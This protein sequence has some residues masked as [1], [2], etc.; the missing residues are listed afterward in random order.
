MTNRCF[1]Q[2]LS[3][4]KNGILLLQVVMLTVPVTARAGQ[5]GSFELGIS[6]TC[7]GLVV[8]VVAVLFPSAPLCAFGGFFSSKYWLDVCISNEQKQRHQVQQKQ[9]LL[10]GEFEGVRSTKLMKIIF[11]NYIGVIFEVVIL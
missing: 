6:L 2:L 11:L 1:A 5:R 10:P 7:L 9:K 4:F 8:E 3:W